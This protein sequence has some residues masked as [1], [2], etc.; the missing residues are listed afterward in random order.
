MAGPGH[1]VIGQGK[2]MRADTI[3]QLIFISTRKVYATNGSGKERV[4]DKHTP[5]RFIN[6]TNAALGMAGRV[7]HTPC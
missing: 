4:T 6:Q 3:H 7:Q 2:Q 1:K 5:V